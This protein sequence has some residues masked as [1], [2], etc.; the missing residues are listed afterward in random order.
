M[1]W[2][3]PEGTSK[4]SSKK[5]KTFTFRL[6]CQKPEAVAAGGGKNKPA[7]LVLFSLLVVWKGLKGPP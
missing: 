5:V 7:N 2:H 1:H 3:L 6:R 4:N